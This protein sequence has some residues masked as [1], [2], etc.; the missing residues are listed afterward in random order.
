VG[1]VIA[2]FG[3]TFLRPT[4]LVADIVRALTLVS[5]VVA[6]IGW[7]G[8]AFPVMALSLLGV[9]VPRMLGLRPAFDV[10]VCTLVL[11]AGWSSVLEWYTSL[12]LWDK[13]I[14]VVLTGLLAAVL[15]VIGADLRAVPA[16]SDER[17]VVVALLALCAGLAVGAAWEMGEWLGHNFVDSAIFVGYDDTIGDLA[18]DGAGGLLAG[19]GLPWLAARRTVVRPGG[20]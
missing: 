15:Y 19:F 1:I 18:A 3:P 12:F 16:P 7:G 2:T 6:S 14:H 9:V 20:R 10:L 8:T 13:L 11:I 4:F 5:L 17:R